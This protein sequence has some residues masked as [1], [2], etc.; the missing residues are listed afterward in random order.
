MLLNAN[1]IKKHTQERSHMNATLVRSALHT[2]L[3]CGI[4]KKGFTEERRLTNV[5]TVRSVLANYFT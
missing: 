4:I 3:R 1:V 2:G 5:M